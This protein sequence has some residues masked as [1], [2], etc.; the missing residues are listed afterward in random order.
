MPVLDLFSYLQGDWILTRKIT[1]L[2]LNTPGFMNGT[3]AI[4]KKPDTGEK[5]VLAYREEGELFFGEYKGKVFRNYEFCFPM[6]HKA[7]VLFSDGKIF[8]ELD[9]SSGF[10]QVEHLCLK[11]TYRGS[12]RVES[13]DVWLSKW[14][15]SGPSKEL[16]LDNHYQRH[17]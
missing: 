9:L 3:T 8:H 7:L 12:F 17:K 10:T 2:K 13:L 5:P 11:D 1:D 6:A 16:I 4:T 15:V 14:Q